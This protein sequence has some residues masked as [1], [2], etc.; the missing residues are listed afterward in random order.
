MVSQNASLEDTSPYYSKKGKLIFNIFTSYPSQ[1]NLVWNHVLLTYADS[2]WYV[3]AYS[4]SLV[5][6]CHI[7]LL[8]AINRVLLTY[9]TDYYHSYFTGSM[10]VCHSVSYAN[11]L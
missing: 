7:P 4:V 2:E 3:T 8:N 6:Q 5:F 11:S 10:V 9:A 1:P